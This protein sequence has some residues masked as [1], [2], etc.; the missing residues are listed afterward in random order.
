MK[1]H[2]ALVPL[3]GGMSSMR[4]GTF[5]AA[6]AILS[7]TGVASAQTVPQIGA[8][9]GI[10]GSSGVQNTNAGALLPADSAGAPGYA[11]TNW[12]N[13][14]VNGTN[15]AA[16]DSSGA[17]TTVTFSWIAANLWSENG[18]GTPSVQTSPDFKLMNGYL[19]S[20]ASATNALDYTQPVI[21]PASTNINDFPWVYVTGVNAWMTA[22]H[23]SQYDVVVYSD[24]DNAGG[25]GGEYWIQNASGPWDGMTLGSDVTTH[26]FFTVDSIFLNDGIYHFIPDTVRSGQVSQFGNF[27]GNVTAFNGLTNDSF[28]VRKNIY[29]FRAGITAVQIVPRAAPLPA[30][31]D[32]L[33]PSTVYSGG[34]AAFRANVGGLVPMSFKWLKNGTPMSDGGNVTGS[35]TPDLMLANVS[36]TDAGNYSLVVSNWAGSVTSSVAPLT[37]TSPAAGSY[38]QM[39]ATNGAVAYWQLNDT[40][41]PSTNYTVATDLIGGL[42]GIYGSAALNGFNGI[43]GPQP[44]SFPAFAT[45]SGALQSSTAIHSWVTAPPLNLSNNTVTITAWIYPTAYAEPGSAGIVWSR[46]GGDVDGLDYQNNNNL[47]YTW[48]NA[49]ATYNFSSGLVIPSNMWSFVAVAITPTNAT[50]YM[51]NANGIGTAVNNATNGIAGFSGLT[52]IGVDPSSATPGG[53]GFIGNIAQAAVFNTT[54]SSLEIYNMYKK[55]VGLS[56]IPATITQQPTSLELY[57]GR[58][59]V[60]TVTGS[61]DTPLTY[62]WSA[63][64]VPLAN[65][66]GISGATSSTLIISNTVPANA[67]T[68]Q[69]VVNNVANKPVTSVPVTLTLVAS[70]AAPVAYEAAVEA[71]G[72]AHYWRFN[73]PVGSAYAYDLWGGDIATN[74]NATAGFSGA[75]GAV[76]PQPPDFPGFETTNNSYTFDATSFFVD[77]QTPVFHNPAQFTILGWFSPSIVEPSGTALFGQPGGIQ[78]TYSPDLT[79]TTPNGGS[80]S[81]AATNI[82]AGFGQWYM[83][84][85]TGDGKNLSMYLVSTDLLVAASSQ[86]PTTNYGSSSSTFLIGAAANT[87]SGLFG[88]QIDEVATFNQALTPS[89]LSTIIGAALNKGPLAPVIASQPAS[90]ELYAGRNLVLNV[91]ALG[92]APIGYFWLENGTNAVNSGNLSGA[93]TETLTITNL[94]L[95]N[96]GTYQFVVTNAAG[97]ATSSV[98]SLTVVSAPS[99]GTYAAAVIADEPIA[100]WDLNEP[101]GSTIDYDYYGGFNGTYQAA[102]TP[103]AAGPRNPPFLGFSSTN[104]AMGVNGAV[105]SSYATAPFGTLSTNNATIVAWLYPVGLQNNWSGILVSRGGPGVEGGLGYNDQQMLDYTWNNNTTWSYVSGLVIPSNVWSMV[106][107]VVYPDQAILYV[108]TTNTIHTATNAIP[109]TPDVFSGNWRIGD[110]ADG[111]PGRGFNG[112]ID[113]VAVFNHSLSPSQIQSLFTIANSG[114]AVTITIKAGPSGY[115]LNWSSGT[116]MQASTPEGPWTTVT[117]NPLPP[118]TF[119]PTGTATFY[120]VKVQ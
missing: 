101:S 11:Q 75:A 48:N 53:R 76:G 86:F 60:F 24:G 118:Y 33:L 120:R 113:E 34:T 20:N 105:A 22:N 63:G 95:A 37:I 39:V 103:G 6:A 94:T 59:A 84:A 41:D 56:I 52:T 90:T 4:R 55:G 65:G 82:T 28:I 18:G 16:F 42:N 73:D 79:L 102:A 36:S 9:F 88:G 30:T 2:A 114:A 71:A 61:G 69:V 35:S 58:P 119:T 115:S 72:P 96:G 27:Q 26:T 1:I 70:N 106:A 14:G 54:L 32:P 40:G 110:D 111:D 47:G 44:P 10:D 50:L 3:F 108:G 97:S 98:V 62:Q 29:N 12:N 112:S 107:M 66:P 116:L 31:I 89:Q 77:A 104:N 19:D 117:G 109:H 21:G 100:Y 25:R 64:G 17:T 81:I 68:Y 51:F 93:G 85:A 13:Y 80:V 92:T 23:V 38:A 5:L 15:A 83:V 43:L 91:S 78:I 99:P 57:Q 45:G 7:L 87:P 49:A 46:N 74:D 8:K 67:T